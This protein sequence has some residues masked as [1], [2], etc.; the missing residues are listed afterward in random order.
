[1][2]SAVGAYRSYVAAVPPELTTGFPV[3]TS[4]RSL[5]HPFGFLSLRFLPTCGLKGSISRNW[6]RLFPAKETFSMSEREEV[7]RYGESGS[8]DERLLLA[9]DNETTW[10]RE[11]GWRTWMCKGRSCSSNTHVGKHLFCELPHRSRHIRRS[12]WLP[13]RDQLVL[14][15][16]RVLGHVFEVEQ[17]VRLRISREEEKSKSVDRRL[18]R[19]LAPL[20]ALGRARTRFRALVRN[21]RR[22]IATASPR[23]YGKSQRLVAEQSNIGPS[24]KP[25]RTPSFDAS[26]RNS[27]RPRPFT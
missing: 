25:S 1:M 5:D 22:R 6:E 24:S 4:S 15:Q 8:V 27:R 10:K 3:R 9:N 21:D 20:C 16:Y 14:L 26:P 17:S 7:R 2:S 18:F 11:T 12:P 23:L 13:R 19:R